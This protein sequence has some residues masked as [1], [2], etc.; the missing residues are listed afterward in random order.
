MHFWSTEHVASSLIRLNKASQVMKERSS[1]EMEG[2]KN[3]ICLKAPPI[4][5]E[6]A[7]NSIQESPYASFWIQADCQRDYFFQIWILMI[8]GPLKRVEKN[9]PGANWVELNEQR[10]RAIL[11]QRASHLH[12]LSDIQKILDF[13]TWKSWKP[14]KIDRK[15]SR[16]AAWLFSGNS[17]R[18]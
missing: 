6:S 15:W 17:C 18:D 2:I 3:S 14:F 10:M 8:L 9:E 11:C 16:N 12:P 4:E 1:V 13:G 7:P 5:S